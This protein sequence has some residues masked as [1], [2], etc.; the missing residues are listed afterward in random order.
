MPQAS[1]SGHGVQG[2]LFGLL[3]FG[4]A[5]VVEIL[6]LWICGSSPF[7]HTLQQIIDGGFVDA[8]QVITLILGLGSCRIDPQSTS[9]LSPSL[10]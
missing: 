5:C 8:G 7:L 3:G 2:L 1:D 9:P 4:L 6:Q 10:G